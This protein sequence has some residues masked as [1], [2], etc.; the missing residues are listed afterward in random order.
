MTMLYEIAAD[1]ETGKHIE[2]LDRSEVGWTEY[3]MKMDDD[4]CHWDHQDNLQ[5]PKTG[6]WVHGPDGEIIIVKLVWR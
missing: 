4:S 3:L 6:E 5:D 1:R 2:I